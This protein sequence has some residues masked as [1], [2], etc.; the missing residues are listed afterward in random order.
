VEAE[1]EPL[2]YTE[3][4]VEVEL[5]IALNTL[6]RNLKSHGQWIMAFPSKIFLDDPVK[7]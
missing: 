1:S 2:F 7:V 4:P 3:V 6:R 5:T